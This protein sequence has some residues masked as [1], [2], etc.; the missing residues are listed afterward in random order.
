MRAIIVF[1]SRYGNTEK[2]ARAIGEGIL[3]ASGAAPMLRA[4]SA[5]RPADVAGFDLVVVGTPDH[6]GRS[7]GSVRRFV[8]ELRPEWLS[9]ARVA[10][11]DTCLLPDSGKAVREL[12][13]E[14]LIVSPKTTVWNPGLSSI[15]QGLRGPL[16]A[17]EVE[18]A[19][20]FGR[21]ITFTSTGGLTAGTERPPSAA[22]A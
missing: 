18:R 11:F 19:R 3:E 7:I 20:E 13:R 9:G 22:T 14:L 1:A 8:R 15:V 16:R 6:F 5:T 4:V 10:F 2:V 17:G 12:E 21:S